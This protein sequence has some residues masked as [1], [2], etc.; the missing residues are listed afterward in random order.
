[1]LFQKTQKISL[2]YI[3]SS[4]DLLLND[5]IFTTKSMAILFKIMD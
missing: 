2:F 3:D 5:T 4:D 1:M